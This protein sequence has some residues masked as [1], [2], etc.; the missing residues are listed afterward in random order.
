MRDENRVLQVSVGDLKKDLTE[1]NGNLTLALNDL[2][3][4]QAGFVK[5]Q[6]RQTQAEK[7][8]DSQQREL[9]RTGAVMKQFQNDLGSTINHVKKLGENMAHNTTKTEQLT[10]EGNEMRQLL[11]VLQS[12]LERNFEGDKS[13]RGEFNEVSNKLFRS[14]DVA[15]KG[16]E[17]ARQM[18]AGIDANLRRLDADFDKQKLL[19]TSLEERVAEVTKTLKRMGGTLSETHVKGARLEEDHDHTKNTMAEVSEQ[20]RRLLMASDKLNDGVRQA[21][22]ELQNTQAQLQNA[23]EAIRSHNSKLQNNDVQ[24]RKLNEG[25]KATGSQLQQMQHS[26]A[27]TQALAQQATQ[28]LKETQALMLPNIAM[29]L[30]EIHSMATVA[31]V[32]TGRGG[33]GMGGGNL[34]ATAPAGAGGKG[35][36][37]GGNGSQSARGRPGKSAHTPLASLLSPLSSTR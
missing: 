9:D 23:Q 10:R 13:D 4:M 14:M 2:K 17:E 30:P 29:D 6:D 22:Q 28:S 35:A 27:N 15:A 25:H 3:V 34:A 16:L 20:T 21:M 33:G 18:Q 31:S 12:D 8:N 37:G 19:S 26:L 36:G 32:A 24:V 1:T 11:K 7:A 5:M